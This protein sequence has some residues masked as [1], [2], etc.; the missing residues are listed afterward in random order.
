MAWN[1]SAV[2]ITV[3][4]KGRNFFSSAG[5]TLKKNLKEERLLELLKTVSDNYSTVPFP[6]ESVGK[7]GKVYVM[8]RYTIFTCV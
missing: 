4:K 5:C 7:V 2:F 6:P 3:I 8:C 1:D